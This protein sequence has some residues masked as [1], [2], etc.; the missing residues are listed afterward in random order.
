MVELGNQTGAISI[1]FPSDVKA[2]LEKTALDSEKSI[3]EVV[4]ILVRQR[5]IQDGDLENE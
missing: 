2:I 5:L 4:K 1:V 3:A